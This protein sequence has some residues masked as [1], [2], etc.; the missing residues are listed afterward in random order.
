[1]DIYDAVENE[2][3]GEVDEGQKVGEHVRQHESVVEIL[4]AG[5]VAD[6]VLAEK[7][8]NFG[9]TD[10]QEEQNDESDERRS[11]PVSG[12]FPRLSGIGGADAVLLKLVGASEC[13]DQTHVTDGENDEGHEDPDHRIDDVVGQYG[14]LVLRV[15][16]PDDLH[17]IIARALFVA[18]GGLFHLVV[19]ESREVY[20]Y[21]TDAGGAEGHPRPA[22]ADEAAGV[23]RT[24]DDQVPA[25]CH[26]YGQPGT[27]QEER[28][29]ERIA[30]GVEIQLGQL[31]PVRVDHLLVGYDRSGQV[32]DADH[33][34]RDGQSN[35]A[36]LGRLFH[37]VH[38]SL[39]TLACQHDEI[40]AV[41]QNAEQTDTGD[42][43]FVDDRLDRICPTEVW[44][45]VE[46]FQLDRHVDQKLP[47]IGPSTVFESHLVSSMECRKFNNFNIFSNPD[48]NDSQTTCVGL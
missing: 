25:D 32:H 3:D 10:E 22:K 2:V 26:R 39:E 34:V 8:Q 20:H 37:V 31:A 35:E 5:S 48:Q 19:P 28:V 18:A 14:A 21:G 38:G 13:P 16:D 9:W 45:V 7:D 1:M 43:G 42:D 15:V 46:R 12:I 40:Q 17:V 27:A 23:K 29:E 36:Q 47:T 4:P 24:A 41:A 33:D 44:G 6:D 30:V 11:D